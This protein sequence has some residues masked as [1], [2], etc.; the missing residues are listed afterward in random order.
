MEDNNPILNRIRKLFALAGSSNEEEAKRAME[1]ANELLVK[2]NLDSQ[3]LKVSSGDYD[4]SDV[5]SFRRQRPHHRHINQLLASFFFVNVIRERTF[6]RDALRYVQTIRLVGRPINTQ[7]ATYVFQYLDR[8][9]PDLWR[10]YR[11]INK[12]AKESHRPSYYKGLTVGISHVLLKSRMAVEEERGLQVV[13]DKDLEDFTNDYCGGRIHKEKA[14]KENKN[15]MFQGIRDGLQVQIS[16]PLA[17]RSG[18]PALPLAI[19]GG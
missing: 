3:E 7:I 12:R 4:F 15:V 18:D 13:K 17:S 2:H 9:Y 19:Q 1:K 5:A 16:P 8:V 14:I 6:D 10:T 11:A